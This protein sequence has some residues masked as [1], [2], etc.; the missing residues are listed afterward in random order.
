M[1]TLSDGGFW[2]CGELC[3]ISRVLQ[4]CICFVLDE[5]QGNYFG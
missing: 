1:S 3:G 4:V 2:N 5:E